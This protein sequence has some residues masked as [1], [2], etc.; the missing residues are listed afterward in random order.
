MVFSA[1]D[2]GMTLDT[3]ASRDD[4]CATQSAEGDLTIDF[5]LIHVFEK[6]RQ[7]P[8]VKLS[9]SAK[10]GLK[11]KQ[12]IPVLLHDISPCG[13]Q[14]RCDPNAAKL[15]NPKGSAVVEDKITVVVQIELDSR[16]VGLV[17][18]SSTQKPNA[19]PQDKKVKF[20]AQVN[21]IYCTP[22]PRGGMAL[23]LRFSAIPPD[24]RKILNLLLATALS[25]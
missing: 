11:S 19:Y 25:T 3:S 12:I 5:P 21:P 8:R 1:L 20:V 22:C 10:I 6:Q 23:G 24:S 9:C 16:T 18:N 4:V 14:I 15:I 17:Q 13:V 2:S 7:Y